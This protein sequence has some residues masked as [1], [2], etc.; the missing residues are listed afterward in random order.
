[1]LQSIVLPDLL[2]SRHKDVFIVT[3]LVVWSNNSDVTTTLLPFILD[4]MHMSPE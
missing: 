3:A 4:S 1:M 2:H